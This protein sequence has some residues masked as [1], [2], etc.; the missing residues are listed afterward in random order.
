MYTVVFAVQVQLV[1]NSLAVHRT[2]TLMGSYLPACYHLLPLYKQ[3]PGVY[4]GMLSDN[5]RKVAMHAW[6]RCDKVVHISTV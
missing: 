2:A 4:V 1:R 3:N 6:L 5:I